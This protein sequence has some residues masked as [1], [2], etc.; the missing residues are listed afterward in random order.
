[1][2][3]V[4]SNNEDETVWHRNHHRVYE[5]PGC[6]FRHE[7]SIVIHCCDLAVFRT[8]GGRATFNG[9]R[10]SCYCILK[11]GGGFKFWRIAFEGVELRVQM[12]VDGF[13]WWV[14]SEAVDVSRLMRVLIVDTF[15]LKFQKKKLIWKLYILIQNFKVKYYYTY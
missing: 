10:S 11:I 6:I 3:K 5:K 2:H 12:R 14:C 1:M 8:N 4:Q 9:P 15:G 13:I 7:F